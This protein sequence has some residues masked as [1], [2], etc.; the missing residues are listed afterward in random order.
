[1]SLIMGLLEGLDEI[2][3]MNIQEAMPFSFQHFYSL[4][5]LFGIESRSP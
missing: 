2:M 1:M 5:A 4:N 3:F